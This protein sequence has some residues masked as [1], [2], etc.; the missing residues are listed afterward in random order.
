[1]KKNISLLLA[2]LMIVTM[3]PMGVAANATLAAP[4]VSDSNG[5][6]LSDGAVIATVEGELTLT[7]ADAATI[8]Q[9]T[10]E[11]IAITATD[12]GAFKGVVAATT[13]ANKVKLRFGRLGVGSYKLTVPATVGTETDTLAEEFEFAFSAAEKVLTKTDFSEYEAGTVENGKDNIYYTNTW[14]N[15]A[16]SSITA[17]KYG[18]DTYVTAEMTKNPGGIAVIGS[19]N[20]NQAK[21]IDSDKVYIVKADINSNLNGTVFGSAFTINP[22]GTW[23]NKRANSLFNIV[24]VNGSLKGVSV[25][26]DGNVNYVTGSSILLEA[27]NG[28]YKPT[29]VMRRETD[30]KIYS[31]LYYR[32]KEEISR[33]IGTDAYAIP[34][35]AEVKAIALAAGNFAAAG[36]I[37]MTYA[38]AYPERLLSVLSVGKYIGNDVEGSVT[39]NMSDDMLEGSLNGI[40]VTRAGAEVENVAVSETADGRGIV[41]TFEGGLPTGNYTVS[42]AGIRSSNGLNIYSES[43][44]FSVDTLN[45]NIS[46]YSPT[47]SVSGD[48]ISTVEGVIELEYGVNIDPATVGGITF[49]KEDGTEIDGKYFVKADG[50][51]V[52]VRFGNLTAGQKYV[53]DVPDTVM[54]AETTPKA[55]KAATYTFTAIEDYLTKVSFNEAGYTVGNPPT[56]F[57]DN[58]RYLDNWDSV[59][60]NDTKVV[61]DASGT[62]M[63]IKTQEKQ[64][65]TRGIYIDATKADGKLKSD[66]F[67]DKSNVDADK[68]YVIDAD[69]AG[70]NGNP[71]LY[72]GSKAKASGAGISAAISGS[73]GAGNYVNSNADSFR[74]AAA[75]TQ[76]EYAYE[77]LSGDASVTTEAIL[78]KTGEWY[79]IRLVLKR[80][81]NNNLATDLY[82]YGTGQFIGTDDAAVP[83]NVVVNMIGVM[84]GYLDKAST[85]KYDYIYARPE[86]LLSIIGDD[87]YTNKEKAITLY[88]SKAVKND[89]ADKVVLKKD[90]TILPVSEVSVGSDSRSITIKFD[91]TGLAAGGYDVDISKIVDADG[92]LAYGGETY[93]FEV[94]A[95]EATKIMNPPT[96][97]DAAGNILANGTE[98]TPAEISVAEGGVTLSFTGAIAN[99][100][101]ITFTKAD[102]S[103]IKGKYIA[104]TSECDVNISFGHLDNDAIYKVTVP[105]TVKDVDD[106]T[107]TEE[108]V[109]YVKATEKYTTKVDFNA[110]EGY[111]V[112][113]APT[114]GQDNL[115]YMA[116]WAEDM[117]GVTIKSENGEN[118]VNV[119]NTASAAHGVLLKAD[120]L[121][122]NSFH[123]ESIVNEKKAYV[124]EAKIRDSEKNT[125]DRYFGMGT[126]ATPEGVPTTPGE[127]NYAVVY[128]KGTTANGYGISG[129]PKI[130]V[131]NSDNWIQPV[132]V[133][134]QSPENANVIDRELYDGLNS[135][136]YKGKVTEVPNHANP[137]VARGVRDK[138][139]ALN[140]WF[141]NAGTG[142]DIAYVYARPET[143]LSVIYSDEYKDGEPIKLYMSDDVD[144]SSIE[145]LKITSGGIEIEKVNVEID[146][147]D[148]RT[149]I[150]TAPDGLVAGEYSVDVSSLI[151]SRSKLR[152]SSSPYIFSVSK[153]QGTTILSLFG[154][155]VPEGEIDVDTEQIELTFSAP[156]NAD[157]V[158][159]VDFTKADGTPIKGALLKNVSGNKLIL[160]FGR[161]E[162]GV[163]YKLE[164]KENAVKSADGKLTARAQI[165]NYT[166]FENY[167][168]YQDF[169][170]ATLP[171]GAQPYGNDTATSWGNENIK[172]EISGDAEIMTDGDDSYL[173]IGR[174]S[175]GRYGLYLRPT[176]A[177]TFNHTFFNNNT[178]GKVLAVDV[179]LR[180]ARLDGDASFD[181]PVL[182]AFSTSMNG[183]ANPIWNPL[184][185]Y[186]AVGG[187]PGGYTYSGM[188]EN[189]P[190][191]HG[192]VMQKEEGTGYVHST[193]VLKAGEDNKYTNIDTT[194]FSSINVEMS[195]FDAVAGKNLGTNIC[196]NDQDGKDWDYS[197]SGNTY[198]YNS[199]DWIRLVGRY[200]ESKNYMDYINNRVQITEFSVI[201]ANAM[202]IL[203]N[204]GYNNATRT[205]SVAMSDDVSEASLENIKITKAGESVDVA[206][207]VSYDEQT[208]TV[209]VKFPYGLPE[210]DYQLDVNGLSSARGFNDGK[211]EIISFTVGADET[212]ITKPVFKCGEK[213]IVTEVVNAETEILLSAAT[214]VSVTA[215]VGNK[216]A[217][218]VVFLGVYDEN[219]NLVTVKAA[220]ISD[221]GVITATTSDFTAGKANSIKLFMWEDMVNIKP[222]FAP[223]CL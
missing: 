112:D 220:D 80:D 94:S 199:I 16:A 6:L 40:T 27:L 115:Q 133:L 85:L 186:A 39:I 11:G 141:G 81:S 137:N 129:T 103:A 187:T 31:D 62:Y 110:E 218:M 179:K 140:Y 56:Q 148:E 192:Y 106:R 118:Y 7:F 204:Y 128:Y 93:S 21:H 216:P 130:S 166:G 54:S 138:R 83:E 96:V 122:N 100:E 157:A 160:N 75:F 113:S 134:R 126:D 205:I 45:A 49:E 53:L 71:K 19:E 201:H 185:I 223:M 99:P 23:V 172:V 178:D 184:S 145:N 69:V 70:V 131:D 88:L 58:L 48:T 46:P 150:I 42:L 132:L 147:Q 213:T 43:A 174:N 120:G 212:Y 102:G 175:S 208:R 105:I 210:G 180:G 57:Q 207:S 13:E 203:K 173:E 196:V 146:P 44:T 1:M 217:D 15:T 5:A 111:V 164:I 14:N 59:T 176:T 17:V 222:L 47:L 50:K 68:V 30:G 32:N 206:T 104:R 60:T 95:D 2:V 151:S 195:L 24:K 64:S 76:S 197:T 214:S 177:K 108:F 87:G 18:E 221:D 91:G 74:T 171:S 125:K 73:Y 66:N 169:T 72:I 124:V 200:Y 116:G 121:P 12:D 209:T 77:A 9:S 29:M 20:L 153:D 167:E 198:F 165:F 84:A 142:N 98:Q 26:Q 35:D 135:Y 159:G 8:D 107:L 55:V 10:L 136:A 202:D 170:N 161:L 149:I 194:S 78:A 82:N 155:S 190:A 109:F 144:A 189:Y 25:L 86:R 154:C 33:F 162:A 63:E 183:A 181:E 61:S 117:T 139:I 38:A 28:W 34:E 219:D 152:G 37:D 168:V 65:K 52:T 158:N 41:L 211:M 4:T 67:N 191:Y 90:G 51:I 22:D 215:T 182:S 92:I 127:T 156:L 193:A 101:V 119:A 123:D 114:Q 188:L 143:L 163:D 3:L 97:K 36:K 89:S 79:K